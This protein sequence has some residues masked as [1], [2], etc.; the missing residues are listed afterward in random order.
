MCNCLPVKASQIRAVLS[1]LPVITTATG[2]PQ[3][4]RISYS[5]TPAC[6]KNKAKLA[7]IALTTGSICREGA[8]LELPVVPLQ[9][10]LGCPT[11]HVPN[12]RR[13]VP[14][15][16]QNRFAVRVPIDTGHKPRVP[17][18]PFPFSPGPSVSGC[19]ESAT[20]QMRAV[21]SSCAVASLDPSGENLSA[22]IFPSH[23]I[24]SIHCRWPRRRS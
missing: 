4:T 9:H 2:T 11:L 23:L 12:N 16:G 6:I 8:P 21:L 3:N 1:S 14:A 5:G 7:A 17:A 13:L 15:A 10:L 20:S 18:C 19:L 24:L 22:W